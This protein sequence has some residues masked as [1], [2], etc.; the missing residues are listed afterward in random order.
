[1]QKDVDL[2]ETQQAVSSGTRKFL[3]SKRHPTCIK[4]DNSEKYEVAPAKRSLKVSV[5]PK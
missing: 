1:M 5:Y 4:E 2:A 3:S